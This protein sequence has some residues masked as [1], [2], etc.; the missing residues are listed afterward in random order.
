MKIIKYLC[1]TRKEAE[2]IQKIAYLMLHVKK[3]DNDLEVFT[4]EF[5]NPTPVKRVSQYGE[6]EGEVRYM[7]GVKSFEAERGDNDEI[8]DRIIKLYHCWPYFIALPVAWGIFCWNCINGER[9]K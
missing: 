1:L 4:G 2:Q 5:E 6:P 9:Q 3:R 8:W 7:V